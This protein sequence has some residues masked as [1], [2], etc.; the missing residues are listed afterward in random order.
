MTWADAFVFACIC[1]MWVYSARWVERMARKP[2][3]EAF[4]WT[5]ADV[6]GRG[7]K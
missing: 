7:R 5:W 3:S 6:T 1:G 2:K 4:R